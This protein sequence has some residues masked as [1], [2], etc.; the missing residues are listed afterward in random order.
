MRHSQYAIVE[1]W[2]GDNSPYSLLQLL[3]MEG[4]LLSMLLDDNGSIEGI[5][6]DGRVE[7]DYHIHAHH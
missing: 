6:R 2:F 5:A 1:G 4:L 3:G 7:R